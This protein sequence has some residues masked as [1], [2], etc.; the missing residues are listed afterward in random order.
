[1][2]SGAKLCLGSNPGSVPHLLCELELVNISPLASAS[3]KRGYKC[4]MP[5]RVN[6]RKK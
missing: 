1:M 2:D 4:H 6:E 5:H 3:V